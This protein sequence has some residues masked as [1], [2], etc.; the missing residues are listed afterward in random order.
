MVE[1]NVAVVRI[2]VNAIMDAT[3]DNNDFVVGQPVACLV[4][5]LVKIKSV[6]GGVVADADPVAIEGADVAV[7]GDVHTGI[8]RLSVAAV[9]DHIA[10]ETGQRHV[11]VGIQPISEG[12]C[13]FIAVQINGTSVQLC[14]ISRHIRAVEVGIT[15]PDAVADELHLF[16]IIGRV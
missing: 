7:K 6:G 11:I 3:A 2:V 8:D 15:T 9:A 1:L 4:L 16:R 14:G 10:A 12:I 5:V 13:H